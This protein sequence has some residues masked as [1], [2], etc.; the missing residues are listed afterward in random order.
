MVIRYIQLHR[1]HQT[2]N[3][4]Y[5]KIFLDCVIDNCNS[6]LFGCLNSPQSVSYMVDIIT[7][8]E[9]MQITR[10]TNE[11]VEGIKVLQGKCINTYTIQV[12][13]SI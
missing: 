12:I 7:T 8:I 6:F 1:V 2:S 10:V 5:E 11:M 13:L 3:I 9:K 4:R